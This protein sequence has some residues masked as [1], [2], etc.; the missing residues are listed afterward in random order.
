MSASVHWADINA[1]KIIRQ[2]GDK[3]PYVCASGITPSGTVHIGNFREIISVDLVVKAL[4][5]T[6]K[7]V[8]FIYSWD[9]FDVFRKIPANMPRKDELEKHLR[10]PITCVPDPNGAAESYARANEVHVERV[11]G[12]VG[13]HPEYI[14]QSEMYGESRYADGIRTALEHKEDIRRILDEH[15]TDPLDPEWMPVSV[16][17]EQ[18]MRDTTSVDRW[19][20]EWKISYT[21]RSCGNANDVDLRRA[22][23]AKLPWRVDWPMRWAHE[24]VDFEPAGKEH[25]SAGGSFDTAKSVVK[26]VYGAEP[27]VTF[28]YDFITIKGTGGKMSSSLGNI[29]SLEDVL[30]IYQPEVVRYLFAGTRPNTEFSISF[31]LDVLK[32]Y[33]DYDRCERV[34]FGLEEIGE[35]RREKEI[36]TYELSQVESVPSSMPPQVPFRHVC[37]LLQI[38]D[39]DVEAAVEQI[40]RETAGSE[41]DRQAKDVMDRMRV[42]AGCAWRWITKFAPDDF[43]FR[44]RSPDDPLPELTAGEKAVVR[45]VLTALEPDFDG[46]TEETLGEALY[47]VMQ[48]HD[49]KAGQ[50]FKLMYRVLLGRDRGPRLAGFI[51]TVGKE[52]ILALLEPYRR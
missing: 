31:D 30:E 41:D 37:N 7:N 23:T 11:L 45:D 43:R 10:Q 47:G 50:F 42:R 15:R 33:E 28:K 19:D 46:F 5:H 4:R 27:P 24:Q 52:K 36:R 34:Y 35:K 51:L 39:G 8:R 6:G 12:R 29:V 14:Y 13:I 38:H 2:R 32:V 22:R 16:F 18:C 49:L 26:A 40:V 25:H 9:D 21:C 1:D 48:K 17:C 44:L 3:D 20:G